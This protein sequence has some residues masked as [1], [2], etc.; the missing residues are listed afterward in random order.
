MKV[1]DLLNKIANGEEVP[2]KIKWRD[3]IWIYTKSQ[4]DYLNHGVCFFESFCQ[5][6][7][8]EFLTDTVEIIE[9]E[10]EI[11]IQGIEETKISDDGVNEFF[12]YTNRNS[13]TSGIDCSVVDVKIMKKINDLI[14]A[15]KQLDNKIKEKE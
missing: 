14:K 15:V 12:Y 13:D 3:K 2:E 9:E 10:P 7:T 4:Q 6:R 11:D 5:I 8:K 1:I